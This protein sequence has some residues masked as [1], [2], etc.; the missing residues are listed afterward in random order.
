[1]K[2]FIKIQEPRECCGCGAC[3]NVCP[4]DAISMKE[5]RAGFIYPEVDE[6]L[7]VKCGKCA[8][9]CVFTEKLRGANGEPSVY[10][11]AT[12]D[13]SV[14]M[15]SSS[16]GIFTELA[17]AVLD[18][19]G[20]VFGAAWT[21]DLA[22]AHICVEDNAELKKLR[23]SKYVQSSTGDTFRQVKELLKEG[24]YVCYSG[25]PC[26][27]AGLKAFI[28]EDCDLLLTADVICHGVPSTKMLR[29]DLSYVSGGKVSQI[30][31]IRFRDKS[32]GW[33]T[34]GSFLADGSKIKY[35]SGCSPYYFYFL[36]GEVYRES[37]YNC[38][39][40]GEGRQGDIT[41][42]DYWGVRQE[43]ISGMG[44]V[45]PDMGISCV[46]V[47]TEKGKKWLESVEGRLAITP[48]DRKTAEKRN[49]QLTR[50]SVPLPEH[51]TLLNGYIEKGYTAFTDGYKKHFKDHVIRTVKNMIPSKTKRRINEFIE[52]IKG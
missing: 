1:M 52:K 31:D 30:S 47:N 26:Q 43:L 4:R 13:K 32:F 27:I 19:G 22:A 46:L 39:F 38:R 3:V 45:D 33:G 23:G 5:D 15:E 34:N 37:C 28:G 8:E 12:A 24:R 36:K 7:C 21:D 14:L 41:L 18:K 2:D 17:N 50:P 40:P 6:T 29:D 35:N 42:G 10:A 44:S 51:E 25:T 16:G 48:S 11:A 49:G 20:A 9:V